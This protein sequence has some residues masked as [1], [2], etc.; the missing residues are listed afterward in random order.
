M[1]VF[2]RT[3]LS[4]LRRR[5]SGRSRSRAPSRR[6]SYYHGR[7]SSRCAPPLLAPLA[8]SS[9]ETVRHRPAMARLTAF[10]AS[11]GPAR[12]GRKPTAKPPKARIQSSAERER[13]DRLRDEG[14]GDAKSRGTERETIDG[15]LAPGRR[16]R[17]AGMAE[18]RAGHDRER[19]HPDRAGG[20]G[21][22]RL[23]SPERTPGPGRRRPRAGTRSGRTGSPGAGRAPA[24]RQRRAPRH[25]PRRTRLSRPAA[26]QRTPVAAAAGAV[27]QATN[28]STAAANPEAIGRSEAGR[29]RPPALGQPVAGEARHDPAADQGYEED[30]G[31]KREP[32]ARAMRGPPGGGVEMEQHVGREEQQ[33][34]GQ[35]HEVA[36]IARRNDLPPDN[37]GERGEGRQI[38]GRGHPRRQKLGEEHR[39][40][41]RAP[42]RQSRRAASRRPAAARS[43]SAPRSAGTPRSPPAGNRTAARERANPRRQTE[44]GATAPPP[45]WRSTA[46]SPRPPRRSPRE[47]SAGTRS[48]GSPA[49]ARRARAPWIWT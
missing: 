34:R 19:H 5:T 15:E 38:D 33:D 21:N 39:D 14:A 46:P 44:S 6:M 1:S 20:P 36:A 31:A 13:R 22:G 49:R 11:F 35:H 27:I 48:S 7:K 47:T 4:S 42:D 26:R 10:G 28:A 30:A 3:P 18:A 37:G 2:L 45:A 23:P 25:R 24:A 32:P 9:P 29:Q 41:P 8:N 43:S 16:Q 40:P 12:T 17:P